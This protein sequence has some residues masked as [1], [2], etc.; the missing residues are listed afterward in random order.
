MVLKKKLSEGLTLSIGSFQKVQR[1][2]IYHLC[3]YKKGKA[4][5]NRQKVVAYVVKIAE[6]MF[7]I[8]Y[9]HL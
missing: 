6:F 3:N 4:A 5:I 9:E 1:E 8:I 2:V 7:R